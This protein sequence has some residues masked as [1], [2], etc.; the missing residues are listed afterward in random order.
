MT[1]EKA[2]DQ[3]H[4]LA[5]LGLAASRMRKTLGE[6]T[7]SLEAYDAPLENATTSSLTALQAY[8]RGYRA[9]TMQGDP[10]SAIRYFKSALKVDP[11][12]AMAYA[13]LATA[14]RNTGRTGESNEYDRKAYELRQRV[15]RRE[16]Y[17]IESNY[18]IGVNGDFE[19]ARNIYEQ[20]AKTYPRDEIPTH[21]LSWVY[22]LL[23][24]RWKQIAQLQEAIRVEPGNPFTYASLSTA[25]ANVNRFDE[26]RQ[27]LQQAIERK[28]DSPALHTR[29]YMLALLE[30]DKATAERELAYLSGLKEFEYGTYHIQMQAALYRGQLTRARQVE[31]Q[32]KGVLERRGNRELQG[33]YTAEL[34]LNE[35]MIGHFAK[36]K[37][38]ALTALQESDHKNYYVDAVNAYA[39]ALAGDAKYARQM[40]DD[41]TAKVPRNTSIRYQYVP[42]LRGAAAQ[43]EGRPAQAIAELE[44]GKQYEMGDPLVL[45][46]LHLQ[47]VYL[48]GQAYLAMNQGPEAAAEFE[49][50][51]NNPGLIADAMVG[52]L[53]HLGLAR[54]YN[55]IGNT[56]K[57]MGAY[58]DFL[59]HFKDADPDLP[60][61]K[62]AQ[63]EYAKLTREHGTR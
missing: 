20:W 18:E 24:D 13:R 53:A 39:V 45:P 11:N 58:Q 8:S 44:V 26:A 28:L 56:E 32:L 22:G 49:K 1:E 38:S 21:N 36:A 2:E 54:A 48:R 63:A 55:L 47:A 15:S 12:F 42:L 23:N 43:A 60:V 17:F 5:A 61:H 52:P 7:T 41:L 19:T 16:Q 46:Y 51:I 33:E 14:Y 50:I 31:E 27:V 35:A 59:A 6:S 9:L 29:I 37:K 30:G 40:A 25:Y 10:E 3:V 62:Q 4:V 34:A 57:A